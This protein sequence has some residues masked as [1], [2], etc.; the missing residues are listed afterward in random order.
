M[1]NQTTND[2]ID[3]LESIGGSRWQKGEMDR[4]YFN[5][6]AFAEAAGLECE[7]YGT[8]NIK[9]A[10]FGGEKLSN[11]RATKLSDALYRSKV[12]VDAT[13]GQIHTQLAGTGTIFEAIVAAA[14]TSISEALAS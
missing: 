6:L 12:Y 8:G 13:T 3:R 2:M 7:T 14:T 10:R 9:N 1:S 5:L 11:N 4:V